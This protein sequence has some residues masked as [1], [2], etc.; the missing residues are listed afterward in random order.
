MII[1]FSGLDGAGKSTQ[2]GKL[3]R[4]LHQR[5]NMVYYVWS[6]GGYTP[7][8]EL[9]KGVFRGILGKKL[10]SS[11]HSQSRTESLS[12]PWVS[13]LWLSAAM[14]DLIFL[15]GVV[16]RLRSQLGQVVI[17]DR[18]LGDTFLDFSLNFPQVEF[19]KMGLWW[20]LVWVTPKPDNSF[21]LLLPVSISIER[22]QLKQEPFPDSEETLEKRLEVYKSSSWFEGCVRI[23]GLQKIEVIAEQ[24]QNSIVLLDAP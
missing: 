18:Y 24:I 8:M 10:P 5:G 9:V 15:Y 20:F 1:T 11:G 17:C 19:E 13:Y 12:S 6:R 2:I 16:V 14:L 22:S 7:G 3:T 23:D 21:L 4:F